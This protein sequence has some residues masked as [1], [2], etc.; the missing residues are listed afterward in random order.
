MALQDKNNQY[1]KIEP[2]NQ[3][4]NYY[5]MGYS[6]YEDKTARTNE[7]ESAQI[8]SDFRELISNKLDSLYWYM[9]ERADE[10]GFTIDNAKDE[11]SI[12]ECLA[13]DEEFKNRYLEY[14][15][16]YNQNYNLE[17][18]LKGYTKM[19]PNIVN[20]LELGDATTLRKALQDAVPQVIKGSFSIPRDKKDTYED[21]TK[22]CYVKA[23]QVQI[24][25]DTIDI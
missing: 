21:F 8:V 5:Y 11:D 24:Y 1:I 10:V 12:S 13:Q 18:Y 25:K 20:L 17:L 15:K 3:D 16:Y 7:K 6:I 14:H 2:I 4:D 19:F 22:F 9:M 23:K